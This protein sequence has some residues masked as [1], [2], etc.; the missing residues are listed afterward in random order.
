MEMRVG[1]QVAGMREEMHR[2]IKVVG[3]ELAIDIVSLN[4]KID[5]KTQAIVERMR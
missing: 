4:R 2:D 1:E 3:K 5:H